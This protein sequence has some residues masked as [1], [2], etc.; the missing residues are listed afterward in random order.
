M[1]AVKI[2]GTVDLVTAI[3]F[4][5]FMIFE[6]AALTDTVLFL[7]IFLLAKGI[8]FATT[9]DIA[10]VLDIFSAIIIIIGSAFGLWTLLVVIVSIYLLQKGIFSW[11][12]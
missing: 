11:F 12:S 6:I 10:S 7:G 8:V 1:V 5:V 2:L 3:L 4:W 9:L